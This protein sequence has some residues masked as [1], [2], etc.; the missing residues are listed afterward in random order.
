MHI[1]ETGWRQSG[2]PRWL[3]CF[4]NKTLCYYIIVKTRGSKEALKILG[5]AFQGIIVS[6]FWKAYNLVKAL[7]KQKRFFHLFSEFKKVSARNYSE[8]WKLF[9][10]TLT[11][12]PD[13]H[14]RTSPKISSALGCSQ[15][16]EEKFDYL[17]HCIILSR[18]TK[19]RKFQG[20]GNFTE[21]EEIH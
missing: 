9:Q 16:F 20:G 7:A 17:Y 1:D 14:V 4:T 2:G 13:N 18:I 19:N 12:L 3:W 6:D 15:R 21:G 10:K 11:R 8:E 5:E